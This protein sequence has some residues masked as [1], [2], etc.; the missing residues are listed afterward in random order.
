LFLL[1]LFSGLW[2]I[3]CCKYE[4]F[5]PGIIESVELEG[6]HKEHL[7][8]LPHNEQGHLQL[9]QVAQSLVQRVLE[10]DSTQSV[11]KPNISLTV[12]ESI[13]KLNKNFCDVVLSYIHSI[14]YFA[15]MSLPELEGCKRKRAVNHW[16]PGSALANTFCLQ[17][18]V[19]CCEFHLLGTHDTKLY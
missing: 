4:T 9:H 17:C 3:T 19:S 11:P 5:P 16:E 18:F 10:C 1:A 6:T 7:V 2:T 14:K 13:S 15:G 8:Q 12:E